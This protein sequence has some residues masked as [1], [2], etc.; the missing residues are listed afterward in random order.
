[1]IA[2]IVVTVDLAGEVSGMVSHTTK[3]KHTI[4]L[5]KGYESKVILHTDREPTPCHKVIRIDESVVREWVSDDP[6]EWAD[7]RRWRNLNDGQRIVYYIANFDEGHGVT[8]EY[9]T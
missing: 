3:Q 4:K 5:D 1:M 2:G 8:F 9:V 6:P 7:P